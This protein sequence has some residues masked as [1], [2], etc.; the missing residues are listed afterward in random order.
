MTDDMAISYEA[1]VRGT[2]VLSSSGQ[3]IGTLEHVLEVPELDVF[4]GLVIATDGGLRFIDADRVGRITRS[5]I[6]C[7]L[8]DDDAAGLPAP[9]G[10]PVY[11]V[12]SLASSG[13]SMHDVLGRFFGRPHWKRQHD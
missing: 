9:E 4:D 2:P 11:R 10:P 1:A 5:E 6:H 13:H 8:S 7:E 12:D 3:R